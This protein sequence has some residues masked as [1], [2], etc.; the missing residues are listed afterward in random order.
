HGRPASFRD[1]ARFSF[2]HGGKDGHP[3][4]VDRET[5]DRSIEWLRDAVGRARLGNSDRLRALRR[6]T[7]WETR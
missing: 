4:P 7:D 6:L 2:A 5:Y 1:P 3:Y